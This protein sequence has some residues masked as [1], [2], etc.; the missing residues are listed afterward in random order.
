MLHYTDLQ[1]SQIQKYDK[2]KSKCKDFAEKIK[3]RISKLSFKIHIEKQ[4]SYV[5]YT[6]EETF[7]LMMY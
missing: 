7:H 5:M 4:K 3:T 1:S 2:T 6:K